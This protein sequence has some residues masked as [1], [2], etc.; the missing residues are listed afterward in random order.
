MW[1][2]NKALRVAIKGDNKEEYPTIKKVIG[3]LQSKNL[4]NLF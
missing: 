4:T 3:V 1:P 2:Y